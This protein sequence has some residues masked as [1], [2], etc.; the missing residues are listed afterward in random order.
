MPEPLRGVN[1]GG[2]LV[3]EPWMTP[4][5]F[6]GTDARDEY[7]FMGTPGAA[8]KL[9]RHHET[10]IT[11]DDFAW[12]GEQ[13]LDLVRLP[14][15]HWV[16]HPDPPYAASADILDAAMDSA[17]RYGL[18]VLLDLHAVSGS[19]NGRDHSGKVGPRQW[20]LEREHRDHTYH[21]LEE[22]AKRYRDHPALWGIEL[23]N[24]P[25]DW[26][27]WQLWNFHR[28]AYQRLAELVRPGTHL[29]FS[30]GYLPWLFR[31][32]V[33]GRTD[34]PVV[35]DTH[36]YQCFFPWD[37]RLSYEEQLKRA[38]RRRQL[39]GWLT[40]AHPV[41]VGEWSAAL[42]DSA[43]DGRGD[44]ARRAYIEAQLEGYAGA[45]GWCFWSYKTEQPDEWNF[46]HLV[47]A[48]ILK[49]ALRSSP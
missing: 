5:L 23:V 9:R 32:T 24:E 20:Y 27:V 39:I 46:R 6:A 14:V 40:R 1:L 11:D 13:G 25:T 17:H 15:G 35:M 18:K 47:D 41:L 28:T 4:T 31:G 37:V 22:L 2:W 49:L 34:C 3:L 44:D 29:V 30:D 45:Y 26:R 42:Y 36:L 43:Y 33:R 7:T 10:Y 38:R 16:L 21:A 12:M 8:A 19:Q 48:G